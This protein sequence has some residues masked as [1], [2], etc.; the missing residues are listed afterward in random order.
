[1]FDFFARGEVAK[2]REGCGEGSAAKPE[3]EP[4]NLCVYITESETID[5]SYM[6]AKDPALFREEGVG[7]TGFVLSLQVPS[8]GANVA[9]LGTWAVTAK[10]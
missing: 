10:N 1:M 6:S 3:A 8:G 7:A 4:G 2:P 9:S 5:A